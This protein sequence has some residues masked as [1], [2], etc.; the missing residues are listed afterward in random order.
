MPNEN[1]YWC[2]RCNR[3][4]SQLY[5]YADYTEWG[6]SNGYYDLQLGRHEINDQ[7]SSDFEESNYEYECQECGCTTDEDEIQEYSE[8]KLEEQE[9]NEEVIKEQPAE[10]LPENRMSV[11]DDASARSAIAAFKAV[12][13]PKCKFV[14]EFEYSEQESNCPKCDTPISYIENKLTN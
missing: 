13:C 10:E 1:K 12:I 11:D 2:P 3:E 5:Y 8:R 14:S 6:R 7:E 9:N 4:I